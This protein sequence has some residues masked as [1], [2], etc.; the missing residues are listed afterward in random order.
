[1][2]T[3]GL[4][5]GPEGVSAHHSP[6]CIGGHHHGLGLLHSQ[7]SRLRFCDG[8]VTGEGFTGMEHWLE[9]LPHSWPDGCPIGTDLR[10]HGDRVSGEGSC[11]G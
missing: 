1:V 8:G 5:I 4:G 3:Q 10:W 11:R 7:S 2:G 9:Q 6:S